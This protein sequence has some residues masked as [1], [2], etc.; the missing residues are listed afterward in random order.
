MSDK[1]YT[2]IT[3]AV[4]SLL[5]FFPEA[6]PLKQKTKEKALEILENLSL[7]FLLEEPNQTIIQKVKAASQVLRDIEVLK[8]YLALA[9]ERGW[10]S[11]MNLMILY[12]EYQ[13]IKEAVRPISVL[14]PLKEEMPEN[15]VKLVENTPV[16]KNVNKIAENVKLSPR[17]NRILEIL[18]AQEKAQV[19]DLQ[20][21]LNNVSKRTLRRDLDELLKIG[22]VERSGEWNQVIYKF[23]KKVLPVDKS[24]KSVEIVPRTSDLS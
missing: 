17:Q 3:N 18:Q 2:E 12:K 1:R 20:K 9:K 13:G 8:N 19:S 22:K 5:E 23:C 11:T 21:A 6:E 10:I 4:Y 16:D 15:K 7:V 24:D 14:I